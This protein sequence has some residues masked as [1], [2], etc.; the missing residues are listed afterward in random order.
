[1]QGDPAGYAI[2]AS[3]GINYFGGDVQVGN[4]GDSRNLC[5]NGDCKTAWPSGVWTQSGNDIYNNNTGNVGIGTPTPK[6]T[7]DV[8]GFLNIQDLSNNAAVF[9]FPLTGTL[10]GLYIRADDDPSTW[11]PASERMYIGAASRRVGIGTTNPQAKLDVNGDV[12]TSGAFYASSGVPLYI[13]NISCAEAQDTLTTRTTCTG[14]SVTGYCGTVCESP[15]CWPGGKE[16]WRYV[17][18]TCNNTFLGYAALPN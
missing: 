7:L 8:R 15:Y 4:T 2:Y 3:G 11:E 10:P 16:G 18:A 5:I 1:E 13:P 9:T 12:K 17:N 6:T 14:Y